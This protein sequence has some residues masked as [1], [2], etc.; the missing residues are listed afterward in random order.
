M[1]TEGVFS[2]QFCCEPKTA[3]KINVINSKNAIVP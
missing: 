2:P 1:A 3:V